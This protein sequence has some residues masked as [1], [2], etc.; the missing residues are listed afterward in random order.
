MPIDFPIERGG[1][2]SF[3]NCSNLRERVVEAQEILVPGARLTPSELDLLDKPIVS[4]A[5]RGALLCERR[6]RAFVAL[7]T[8]C[9]PFLGGAEDH[10][11]MEMLR[12]VRVLCVHNILGTARD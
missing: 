11:A 9:R 8:I 2:E 10:S 7:H 3:K 12:K 6:S 4:L 1:L 5:V